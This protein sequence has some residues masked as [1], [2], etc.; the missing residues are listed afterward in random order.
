ML[1]GASPDEAAIHP[2]LHRTI[3]EEPDKDF[4]RAEKLFF[5]YEI[6]WI[7]L[8]KKTRFTG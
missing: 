3:R 1:H 7:Y 8:N 4:Y 2:W 5:S 6:E